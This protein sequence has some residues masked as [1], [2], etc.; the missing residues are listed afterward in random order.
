ML[1][2]FE[3]VKVKY[4]LFSSF[5][6]IK[7]YST[8]L[9]SLFLLKWTPFRKIGIWKSDVLSDS[10]IKIRFFFLC[11]PCVK[12]CKL[13][14]IVRILIFTV[15]LKLNSFKLSFTVK[16]TLHLVTVIQLSMFS[17]FLNHVSRFLALNSWLDSPDPSLLWYQ[18]YYDLTCFKTILSAGH[19]Y[20]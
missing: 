6:T 10:Y 19:A 15:F 20:H 7:L 11:T 3:P 17:M 2:T 18:A 13:L 16:V 5:N 14:R 12:T 1:R 8:A 4:I 9:K